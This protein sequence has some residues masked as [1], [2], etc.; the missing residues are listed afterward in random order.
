MRK[1]FWIVVSALLCCSIASAQKPNSCAKGFHTLYS[2]DAVTLDPAS[3]RPVRVA[4]PDGNKTLIITKDHTRGDEVYM[5][6]EVLDGKK[7]F[8]ASLGGFNG[9]VAWAPDSKAF[10]VTQTE[11]GGG[12][13]SRVYVFYV[14]K[15]SLC[16]IDVS[17][18][19]EKHFGRPVSARSRFYQT[20]LSF[21]GG[22]TPPPCS[23]RLKWSLLACAAAPGHIGFTK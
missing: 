15:S 7:R 11:G 23:W 10:A 18:P 5:R 9:E 17:F 4:S 12:F 13:G 6:Y 21:P 20:P 1:I 8:G 2:R 3:Y 22:Q 19:V 16:K 14:E